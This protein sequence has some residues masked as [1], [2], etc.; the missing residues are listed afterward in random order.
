VAEAYLH[1][2]PHPEGLVVDEVAA[3]RIADAGEFFD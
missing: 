3:E 2:W 1:C